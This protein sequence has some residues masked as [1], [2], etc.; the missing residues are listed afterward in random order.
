MVEQKFKIGD[1]VL[2]KGEQH[3]VVKATYTYFPDGAWWVYELENGAMA[4]ARDLTLATIPP[5][6]DDVD[7][8][9]KNREKRGKFGK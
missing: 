9:A 8:G 2:F 3:E 1:K 7:S 4:A 5:K 6:G